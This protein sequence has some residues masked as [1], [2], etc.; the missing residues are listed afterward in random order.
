MRLGGAEEV[1]LIDAEDG[2]YKEVRITLRKVRGMER[3]ESA[4][5]TKWLRTYA[6]LGKISSLADR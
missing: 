1:R 4:R 6:S 5:T 2:E 3:G